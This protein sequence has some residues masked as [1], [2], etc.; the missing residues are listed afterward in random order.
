MSDK[1]TESRREGRI[2]DAAGE[3]IA[4]FGY[5]KTTVREIA[6]AAGVSKGSIY[7]HFDSKKEL[8]DT[9][10]IREF[11]RV[12]RLWL[13]AMETDEEPVTIGSMFRASLD[14]HH[15]SELM[16]AIYRQDPEVLGG[17][18]HEPGNIFETA[19]SQSTHHQFVE[20][21]QQAGL[22]RN[23][24]DTDVVS[25][26][27]DIID[28]GFL[29]IVELKEPDDIPSHEA[30]IELVGQM[31]DRVLTPEKELDRNKGLEVM[32]QMVEAYDEI[33]T[34]MIAGETDE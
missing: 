28:Y 2:L 29:S 33:L 11:R 8:F 25:H 26:V 24:V 10:L 6:D 27:M 3:L 30:T 16:A 5:D 19:Y 12:L 21:M 7:L 32:R 4:R 22:I 9:L 20:Q 17:Y 13:K 31:L 23:E 34:E 14:T 18:L 1:S 15:E